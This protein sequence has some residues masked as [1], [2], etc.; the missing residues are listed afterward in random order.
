MN[1]SLRLTVT[2]GIVVATGAVIAKDPLVGKYQK[3]VVFHGVKVTATETGNQGYPLM[4]I[5]Q[6]KETTPLIKSTDGA[7]VKLEVA[8]PSSKSKPVAPNWTAT[9]TD[10]LG[11]TYKNTVLHRTEIPRLHNYKPGESIYPDKPMIQVLLFEKPL[12]AAKRLTLT[13]TLTIEDS[14]ESLSIRLPVGARDADSH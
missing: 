11:N 9:L 6:T 1:Q 14:D 2:L 3:P 5:Y 12:P 4:S 10:D 8:S 13:L 7:F